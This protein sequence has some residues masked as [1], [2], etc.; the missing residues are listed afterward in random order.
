MDNMNKRTEQKQPQKRWFTMQEL[1]ELPD[2]ELEDLLRSYGY[3]DELMKAKTHA[4]KLAIIMR[5][6][7]DRI[8]GYKLIIN[9]GLL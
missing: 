7:L 6:Q 9:G 4:D 8:E 1:R 2:N 5:N 3:Q